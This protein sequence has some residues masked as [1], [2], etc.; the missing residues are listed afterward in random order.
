ML[1][2]KSI[3][4]YSKYLTCLYIFKFNK[5][6]FYLN[7]MI[8]DKSVKPDRAKGRVPWHVTKNIQAAIDPLINTLSISRN[9][10]EIH[11]SL[12]LIQRLSQHI[13]GNLF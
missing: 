5:H 6:V 1:Y 9:R 4:Q 12:Q 13:M 11:I 2:H 8:N 10:L 3:N 7:P